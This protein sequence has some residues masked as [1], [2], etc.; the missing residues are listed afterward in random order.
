MTK[1]NETHLFAIFDRDIKNIDDAKQFIRNLKRRGLLFHFD[2]DI[3]DCLLNHFS[4][5]LLKVVE[6]KVNKIYKSNFDW[7]KCE[8]PIGYILELLEEDENKV[9]PEINFFALSKNG[10]E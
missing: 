2:D 9:L 4:L 5:K 7:G 10:V 6:S 3:Y 8:C 1:K